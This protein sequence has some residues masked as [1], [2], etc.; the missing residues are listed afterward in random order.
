MVFKVKFLFSKKAIIIDKIFT[1]N[2]AV[3]KC[4]IGGEDFV[5]FFD[6]LRKKILTDSATTEYMEIGK[7]PIL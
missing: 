6:L 5:N 1:T 7:V 4:Q 2:L 3:C